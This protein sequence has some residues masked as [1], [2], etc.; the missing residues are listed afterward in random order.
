MEIRTTTLLNPLLID[1]NCLRCFWWP[2]QTRS[3]KSLL[4][5]LFG[6]WGLINLAVF[7]FLEVCIVETLPSLIVNVIFL[8]DVFPFFIW[9]S[10]LQP[11]V[12]N[13]KTFYFLCVRPFRIVVTLEISMHHIHLKTFFCSASRLR[14]WY[15]K[16]G[17]FSKVRHI[18]CFVARDN[19]PAQ[20]TSSQFPR[21]MA[22]N[23]KVNTIFY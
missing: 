13:G 20:H 15:I 17:R 22:A 21:T 3:V 19:V 12:K 11:P 5:N 4:P 10:L 1:V 6:G 16:D 18:R 8:C 23:F 7:V 2:L 14:G 9:L